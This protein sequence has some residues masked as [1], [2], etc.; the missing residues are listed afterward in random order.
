[1]YI[2][3][4]QARIG[5]SWVIAFELIYYVTNYQNFNKLKLN[6]YQCNMAI[7]IKFRQNVSSRAWV[8]AL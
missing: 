7:Y 1:M 2:K 6:T 8:S 4:G 5:S 3:F